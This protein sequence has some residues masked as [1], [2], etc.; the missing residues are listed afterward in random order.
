MHRDDAQ[1][2]ADD[3]RGLFGTA[4]KM[5]AVPYD[6]IRELQLAAVQYRFGSLRPQVQLLDRLAQRN[7]VDVIRSIDDGARLLY[8]SNVY[9]SYPF[10]WLVD[11]E[12]GRLTNWLRQITAHDLSSVDVKGVDSLDE[13]FMR[14]ESA[15]DLRV[16]HSSSTTGKLSF[17]PRGIDEWT[18]RSGSLAFSYEAAGID[19]GPE[20]IS[21]EGVP[22][23]STFYRTGHSAILMHT[24]WFIRNLT[25]PDG[26]HP[27]RVLT[28]HPGALSSDLMVLAGRLRSGQLTGDPKSMQLPQRLLERRGELGALLEGTTGERIDQ[29]VTEAAERFGGQRVLVGGVW[30]SMVDAAAAALRLGQ[31]DVF[32]PG[33]FVTSGGGEKGRVLPDNARE[34][35]MEWTGAERLGEGYGMS[36]LMGANA[37]CS[38]GKFHLN[39]W[40]VP[41]VL[42]A[43]TLDPLPAEGRVR[44]RLAGI[45]LMASS[46]W[47]GYIST[48]FVTLVWDPVCECG[49]QG[50]YLEPE[51]GRVDNVED[52]KVSCAATPDAHDET[53][54]FLRAQGA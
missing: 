4:R 8:P 12:Y 37:K 38:F 34:M 24:D 21:L 18:R 26:T 19:D 43:D 27:E 23:I 33:S 49:R 13:W 50:P 20:H 22:F 9:K 53:I 1:L 28:L 3:P 16:C 30:P 35:V 52:D 54:E 15:T 32:D 17:V 11:Q 46:Y 2:L 41:Y 29:F 44:G 5:F 25:D 39:P 10:G 36:E 42:D 14:L 51:I 6:E 45:D 31:R 48:D 40:L 7:G 47:S